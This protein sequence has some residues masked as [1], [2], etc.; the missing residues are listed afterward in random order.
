[1]TTIHP[2]LQ[3]HLEGSL[4]T[5]A[6][7][8]QLTR[9]DGVVMRFTDHFQDITINFEV[10]RAAASFTPT[11]Q[12]FDN[13]ASPNN[14]KAGTYFDD[15]SITPEDVRSGV[16]R[17]AYY[18]FMLVNYLDLPASLPSSKAPILGSG[19]ISEVTNKGNEE[20]IFEYLGLSRLLSQKVGLTTQGMCQA[21][22]GDSNCRKDLTAFTHTGTVISAGDGNKVLVTDLVQTPNDFFNGVITFNTGDNTGLTSDIFEHPGGGILRLARAMPFIIQPGDFFTIITGCDKTPEQCNDKYNNIANYYAGFPFVPGIDF[23][24]SGTR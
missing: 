14:T 21:N 8:W 15:D 11:A 7:L 22:L 24:R 9:R 6:H 4:L 23:I 5:I 19:Y 17:K 16:Y 12:V 13:S 3:N 2:A 18:E 1:M 10:F 20:F